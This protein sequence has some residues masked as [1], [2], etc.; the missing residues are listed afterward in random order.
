MLTSGVGDTPDS[1]VGISNGVRTGDQVS[2]SLLLAGL[3]V[4]GQGVGHRVAEVVLRVGIGDLNLLDDGSDRGRGS[5]NSI[6]S[7]G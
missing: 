6:T 4:T 1:A 7:P 2:V 3:G 5:L